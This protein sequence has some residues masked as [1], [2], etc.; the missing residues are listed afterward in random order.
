MQSDGTELAGFITN[1]SWTNYLQKMAEDGT[2]GDHLILL[3]AANCYECDILV[4]SST[5]SHD[6]PITPVPPISSAVLLILGHIVEEH[7]VSLRP[8]RGGNH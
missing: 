2:W 1:P 4:V 7:Y 6:C 8:L 3:A 5:P